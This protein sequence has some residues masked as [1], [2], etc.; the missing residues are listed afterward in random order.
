M[1][2]LNC[3]AM[4]VIVATPDKVQGETANYAIMTTEREHTA[5]ECYRSHSYHHIPKETV[6]LLALLIW[7]SR[8]K[9]MGSGLLY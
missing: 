1:T 4:A 9:G 6:R 7:H 8:G 2:A 5:P 3:S